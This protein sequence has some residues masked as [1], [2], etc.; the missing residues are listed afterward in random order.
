MNKNTRIVGVVILAVVGYVAAGPFL[1]IEE[2]KSGIVERDAKKLSEN[3][4][5]AILKENLKDQLDAIIINKSRLEMN[6]NFFSGLMVGLVATTMVDPLVD[7]FITPAGLASILEGKELSRLISGDT[8]RTN[9]QKKEDLL[10]NAEYSYDSMSTFS[11]RIL[12]NKDEETK[13]V[14]ER[15]GLSWKLVNIIV[16]MGK[17]SRELG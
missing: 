11:V 17:T 4:E 2:I 1:T 16:P 8:K 15:Y 14:L 7:S 3:I 10:K 6:N 12:N 13:I 9:L 5:F